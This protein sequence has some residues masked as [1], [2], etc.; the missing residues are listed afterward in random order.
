MTYEQHLAPDNITVF[1][2]A[3][4]TKV[5]QGASPQKVADSTDST[6][7]G[8]RSHTLSLMEPAG[9]G[10]SVGRSVNKEFFRYSLK[11]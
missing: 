9:V 4:L 11:L 7:V 10:R 3:W 1:F 2:F 6:G 8:G 5:N